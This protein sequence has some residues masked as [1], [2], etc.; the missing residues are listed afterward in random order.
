MSTDVF[1]LHYA[2][3]EFDITEDSYDSLSYWDGTVGTLEMHL[4]DG[5]MLTITRGPAI[6]V[7][8]ERKPK[9]VNYVYGT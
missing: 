6:P 1:T 7:A 8:V 5:Q 3:K 9:P 2:G 4:G